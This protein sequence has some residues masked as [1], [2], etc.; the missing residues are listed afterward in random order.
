[1][2]SKKQGGLSGHEN[3]FGNPPNYRRI[4]TKCLNC[5]AQKPSPA[6][7]FHALVP[8]NYSITKKGLFLGGPGLFSWATQRLV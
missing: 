1:M 8:A 5:C 4:L 3:A 6:W 7:A 2:K